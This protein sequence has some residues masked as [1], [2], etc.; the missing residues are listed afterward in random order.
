M[1]KSFFVLLLVF[2]F[3]AGFSFYTPQNT[4]VVNAYK[5][6]GMAIVEWSP[7]N[8]NDLLNITIYLDEGFI[9]EFPKTKLV[10]LEGDSQNWRSTL[11]KTFEPFQWIFNVDIKDPSQWF[12]NTVLT[13]GQIYTVGVE[14]V[15]LDP[16]KNEKI[17]T[18]IFPCEQPSPATNFNDAGLVSVKLSQIDEL[19]TSISPLIVTDTNN[20]I[21]YKQ[22]NINSEIYQILENTDFYYL[23]LMDKNLIK[24]EKIPNRPSLYGNKDLIFRILKFQLLCLVSLVLYFGYIV[25]KGLEYLNYLAADQNNPKDVLRTLI[26]REKQS[27][28]ILYVM[29][30]ITKAPFANQIIKSVVSELVTARKEILKEVEKVLNKHKIY[31]FKKIKISMLQIL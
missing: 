14:R 10:E 15:Y 7:S 31:Q 16:K 13:P 1:K 3:N 6:E 22:A 23:Y 2:V 9:S 29:I 18:H 19:R 26:M 21:T 4:F 5:S 27:I 20:V 24:C 11:R 12:D 28:V 17:F 30:L 8:S 25:G